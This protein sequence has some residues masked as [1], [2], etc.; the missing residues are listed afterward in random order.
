MTV[1]ALEIGSRSLA[2]SQVSDDIGEEGIQRCPI[3]ARGV[4]DSCRDLL[5]DVAGGN[6]ITR[7]GIASVGPIDMAAGVVAPSGI[8]EWRMG[9]G[10]VKAVQKLFPNASVH[11]GLDGACQA[12][13]E[14]HFGRAR[15]VPDALVII[16]SDRIGAGVLVGG[17]VVV[18]RTG[19]GGQLGHVLVPGFDDVCECGG[20]GCLEAVAG[21]LSMLNWARTQ[22]WPGKSV[23]DLL[24][25]AGE[26]DEI[27]L[28]AL[29]RAGTALGRAIASSAALLDLDLVVVGGRLAKPHTALWKAL[30]A[31]V[32]IHARLSFLTGL[33]VVPSELGEIGVLA[34][35]GAL[36][37]LG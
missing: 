25:A 7:V 28:A 3:P 16:L 31:A 10:L 23:D 2:A 22:G 27:A 33:R 30:G 24:E 15:G 11:L 19:N 18:G 8:T 35:A 1:L 34:G 26:S 14:R 6:E 9:F 20:R 17:L 13:A 36:A 12:V 37:L 29:N 4:W 32:A 5:L 21:G